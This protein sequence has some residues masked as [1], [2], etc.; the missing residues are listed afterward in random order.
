MLGIDI[1]GERS[2]M[3]V[4]DDLS[5]GNRLEGGVRGVCGQR[6]FEKDVRK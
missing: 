5:R 2:L 4:V 3:S 6:D 1:I